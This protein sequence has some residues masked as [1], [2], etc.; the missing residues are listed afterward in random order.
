MRRSPH[1]FPEARPK[2]KNYCFQRALKQTPANCSR[3]R[4]AKARPSTWWTKLAVSYLARI[5]NRTTPL[6]STTTKT[7]TWKKVSKCR[8]YNR[9]NRL[10]THRDIR[11]ERISDQLHIVRVVWK[12]FDAAPKGAHHA[13]T[14]LSQQKPTW[15]IRILADCAQHGTLLP[16]TR[17]TWWM[18]KLS[19]KVYQVSWFRTHPSFL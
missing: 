2:Q 19:R 4:N 13:R 8:F 17:S 15:L 1:H 18:R 11:T 12:G 7:W 14:N 3:R 16:E 5:P 9:S 6:K 10:G